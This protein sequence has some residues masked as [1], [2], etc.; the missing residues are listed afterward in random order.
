M[1][2]HSTFR[3]SYWALSVF[4]SQYDSSP[5]KCV[6]LIENGW[7]INV[8]AEYFSSIINDWLICTEYTVENCCTNLYTSTYVHSFKYRSLA[9]DSWARLGARYAIALLLQFCCIR[10]LYEYKPVVFTIFNKEK[11]LIVRISMFYKAQ[12][13]THA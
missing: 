10:H 5:C 3:L 8:M 7:S 6:L 12:W 9:K 13:K 1:P 11:L 2:K 4:K